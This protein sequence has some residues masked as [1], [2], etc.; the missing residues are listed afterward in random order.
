MV[1]NIMGTVC[2]SLIETIKNNKTISVKQ[3]V[4]KATVSLYEEWGRSPYELT[5]HY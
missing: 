4:A 3:K 2:L 5:D 1:N